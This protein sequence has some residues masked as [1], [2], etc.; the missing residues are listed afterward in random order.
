MDRLKLLVV[1]RLS[2]IVTVLVM[3]L[4]VGVVVGQH[5]GVYRIMAVALFPMVIM[6][7]TVE[8]LSII[9]ME[10]GGKEALTISLGTFVVALCAYFVMSI[11]AVEDFFFAFPEVL[12]ALIGLQI[13]IGR[14]TGYRLS[15]YVR[16]ANF[17]RKH[18]IHHGEAE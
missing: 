5:F 17:R 7:M 12:F 10:K 14:Y 15:E 8:R 16:F 11:N 9:L 2:V 4:A 13:M 1:P 18:D 6:T 3:I